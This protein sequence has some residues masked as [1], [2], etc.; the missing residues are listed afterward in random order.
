VPCVTPGVSL[1]HLSADYERMID[2]LRSNRSLKDVPRRPVVVAERR[3]PGGGVEVLQL[4]QLSGALI[5]LCDG[6]RTLRDIARSF[7]R[8]GD[9][10]DRFP[11]EPACRFALNDLARQGLLVF[12]PVAA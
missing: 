6:K 3:P 5:E 1:L 2:C 7:P 10:L 12:S 4:S 11:K 8:L 9:G